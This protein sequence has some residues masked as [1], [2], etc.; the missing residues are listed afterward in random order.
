MCLS[1]DCRGGRQPSPS[2]PGQAFAG[3]ARQ[4]SGSLPVQPDHPWASPGAWSGCGPQVGPLYVPHL[5]PSPH[6]W[7][8]GLFP[9]P[10]C[11]QPRW[12][13][14]TLWTLLSGS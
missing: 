1:Q 6:T 2:G 9:K 11:F 7:A 3:D 10:C 14:L 8:W 5:L 12:T 4:L 13:E